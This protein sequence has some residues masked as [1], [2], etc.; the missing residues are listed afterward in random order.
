MLKRSL[1]FF[2]LFIK[3]PSTYPLF[4]RK[5]YDALWPVLNFLASHYRKW[6]LPKKKFI[7]I[8]GS[9][10]KTSTRHALRK[11]FLLDKKKQSFSNY[12]SCLAENVLRSSPFDPYDVIEVGVDR[13]G[14]MA[15][16]A[17][18]LRP[19]IVV[20]T[21]IKSDHHLAFPTLEITRKE[22]VEMLKALPPHGIA[23][24]NGDDPNVL[25]M[26]QHT[27][28]RIMT[29]G[30]QEHNDFQAQV[31]T[32]HKSS[33]TQ[34]ILRANNQTHQLK[35]PFL[36]DHRIYAILGA[37]ACACI[38]GKP[39]EEISKHLPYLEQQDSRLEV[40]HLESGAV[41]IDDSS[42]GGW[43]TYESALSTLAQYPGKRKI[44]IL[45]NVSEVSIKPG[46]LYRKLGELAAGAASQ[47]T[48]IGD[49]N[50]KKVKAEAKRR[51]MPPENIVFGSRISD[52]VDALKKLSP[53]G[54]GDVIL[55]KGRGRN[56]FSRIALWLEGADL[57]CDVK[58]CNIKTENCR[59]CPF[60]G[61]DVTEVNNTFI[62]DL[63]QEP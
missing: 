37:V 16:Y 17:K 56:R 15:P 4:L 42:K 47:L 46:P 30:F 1:D 49:D 11:I 9:L 55:V 8:V 62:Q 10:G 21:S 38:E 32:S 22:K 53:L 45:G 18:L 48:L 19:D 28:A 6:V 29:F 35:I 57:V 14:E 20:V 51:G 12:G 34:F 25:W 24:L 7:V 50:L 52:A 61:K 44:A 54:K 60:V 13:V 59:P 36:G 3:Y 43:E 27:K 2:E 40:S 33:G 41:V 31:V 63:I 58:R 5:E 26:R 39:V 23:I